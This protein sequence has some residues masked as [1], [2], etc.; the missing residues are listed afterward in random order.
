MHSGVATSTTHPKVLVVGASRG[1][2]EAIVEAYVARGAHVVGTVRSSGTS[3]L[4]DFVRRIDGR[5]EIEH[6]DITVEQQ[7][8]SLRSR[9]D[10]RVF[11]LLFVVA[12]ISLAAQ[13]A[14][15]ADIDSA[16][17]GRMM[18][19]NV[20]G[21]M[22]TVEVLQD[23]VDP[24][25]T[26]AVMSSGQGSVA[27]NTT[28]GFEVYRATKSALNQ[29]FRSYAV[30]HARGGRALLLMAPGWVKTSLG[31]PNAM[32]EISDSIPPLIDT[33]D[34]QHGAPGLRYLDR[35]GKTVAW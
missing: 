15:G 17:F 3:P 14:V 12:G 29:M 20:L 35:H 11:D 6:V 4:H 34:A 13:D 21:V 27:G 30:R 7:I 33:V 16:A 26:I 5:V 10:G 1:L 32:L 8:T 22:R 18:E 19:T 24:G 28:G 31:G 23:L 25:G 9:L 2:G